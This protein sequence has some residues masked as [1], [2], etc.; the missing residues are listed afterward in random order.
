MPSTSVPTAARSRSLSWAVCDTRPPG[1]RDGART[2]AEILMPGMSAAYQRCDGLRSS[3][4]RLRDDPDVR[5]GRLPALREE[6]LRG[7]V[8]DGAG[9][10]DL[11]ALLPVGGRRD[12][13]VRRQL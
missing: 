5:L 2:L 3:V 6:L 11:V 9:D 7:L 13:V 12:L 10:D 1:V 8:A 4:A